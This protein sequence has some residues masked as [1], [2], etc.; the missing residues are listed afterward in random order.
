MWKP[1]HWSFTECGRCPLMF[2][3][4]LPRVEMMLPLVDRRPLL[5]AAT[6]SIACKHWSRFAGSTG[7]TLPTMVEFELPHSLLPA[8]IGLGLRV[9]RVALFQRWWS[10]SF[11]VSLSTPG[12]QPRRRNS[13]TPLHGF[14]TFIRTRSS[15][16]TL[17]CFGAQ[18]GLWTGALSQRL[19]S[20]RSWSHRRSQTVHR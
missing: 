2:I 19:G 10:L 3:L 1:P 14:A 12:R 16:Q 15:W 13:S 5:R 20:S 18:L 7:G 6:F 4:I 11:V 9:L 8:S 17:R